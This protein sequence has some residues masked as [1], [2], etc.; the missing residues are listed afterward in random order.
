MNW[1]ENCLVSPYFWYK[2]SFEN[3]CNKNIVGASIQ[4]CL[5][6]NPLIIV[7]HTIVCQGNFSIKNSSD[8]FHEIANCS[9]IVGY[10]H[11][12]LMDKD[13]DSREKM[14]AIRLPNLVEITDYLLIFHIKYVTSL[15]WFPNLQYIR[16]NTTF[17]GNAL[18]ILNMP[19]LRHLGFHSLRHVRGGV[20]IEEANKLCLTQTSDYSI[21]AEAIK[22]EL[23]PYF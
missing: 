22:S 8:N 6:A 20:R 17:R 16:G 5:Y 15:D 2:K 21:L 12:L 11:I 7:V 14:D 9:R 3:N 19:N 18:I 23:R 1:W 13:L 4:P 10:L